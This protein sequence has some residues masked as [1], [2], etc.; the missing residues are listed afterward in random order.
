MVNWRRSR[1]K[2]PVVTITQ[3]R[4]DG[5]V[6]RIDTFDENALAEALRKLENG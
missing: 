2:Q 6:V 5:V 4:P 3:E 1:P